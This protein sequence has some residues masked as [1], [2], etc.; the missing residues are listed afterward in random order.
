MTDVT[1]LITNN[2]TNVKNILFLFFFYYCFGNIL[3][4]ISFLTVG[5]PQFMSPSVPT[6]GRIGPFA[7]P[8]I[9]IRANWSFTYLI[10]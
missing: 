4:V 8:S 3:H 10:N 6:S 2:S 1:N 5:N 9:E 7:V